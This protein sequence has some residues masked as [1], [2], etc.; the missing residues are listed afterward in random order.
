MDLT[1]SPLDWSDTAAFLELAATVL[2]KAAVMGIKLR[3]GGD[4]DGDGKRME[5]GE[6]DLVHFELVG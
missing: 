2:E 3:Y 5:R 1:P 4:W 6:N